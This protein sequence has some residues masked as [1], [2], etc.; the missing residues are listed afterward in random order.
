MRVTK[1]KKIIP[2]V[3]FKSQT[4]CSCKTLCSS[5]ID[6]A[7]QQVLFS[8]YY[9]ESNYT[10]KVLILRSSVTTE[11]ISSKRRVA[12]LPLTKSKKKETKFKFHLTNETGVSYQ[13]CPSFFFRMYQLQRSTVY[14]RVKSVSTNPSA[15]ENR[16]RTS[17]KSKTSDSEK[18][19]VRQFINSLPQ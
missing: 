19:F 13:V 14:R 4:L 3:E 7:R 2:A 1:G 9:E 6:I 15:L 8:A 16:G 17:T 12:F 5:K 10:Q 18:N 11:P